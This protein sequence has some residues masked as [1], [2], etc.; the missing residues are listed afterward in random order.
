[1]DIGCGWGNMLKEIEAKGAHGTGLT[2]SPAQHKYCLDSGW[3]TRLED[4][5]AYSSLSEE[6]LDLDQLT[7]GP[8]F[9][10]VISIGAFEHFCSIKDFEQGRQDEIYHSFFEM[11]D[12][13]L[14]P[15]GKLYLQTMIWGDRGMPDPRTD[16]DASA[17]RGSIPRILA[18]WAAYFP[19]SFLPEGENQIVNAAPPFFDLTRS[20]DGRLDYVETA[21]VW[22]EAINASGGLGKLLDWGK[23]L[24]K[25]IRRPGLVTRYK[26]IREDAF[27]RGFAYNAIGHKRLT[28]QKSSQF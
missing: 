13:C 19:G 23:F 24:V 22:L 18:Q 14:K 27:S 20:E 15:G 4:W 8:L 28:F 10:G 25:G 21:R 17:P 5:K 11:V 16:F 26:S 9:D 7:N 6:R 2:L 12:S 3:E 1:L